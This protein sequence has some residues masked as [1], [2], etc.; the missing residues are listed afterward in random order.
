MRYLL[1]SFFFLLTITTVF[2]QEV[3]NDPN[4][5][6]QQ[7]GGNNSD[8]RI[9]AVTVAGKVTLE[10]LPPSQSKPA[11]YIIVYHNSRFNQ[12]QQVSNSGSY[13]LNNVPRFN[14]ILAIEIEKN[15][16]IQYSIVPSASS[17]IYQDFFVSWS[18]IQNSINSSNKPGVISAKDFYQR[19]DENQKLFDQALISVKEKKS[20]S[21]IKLFKQIIKN[22]A[23]DFIAWTQLGNIYFINEKL[24]EAEESYAQALEQKPDYMLAL[25]NLG[26]VQ[27]AKNAN[28]KAIA[29]LTKLVEI[30]PKSADAQHYLGEAYLQSKKGSKAVIYLNE[31]IRLA[32]I[33]KAEVHLRLATLYHGAGL[34]DRAALEYKQFLE[35]VS[36]YEEKDKLEKYVKENLPA[37]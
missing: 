12:R 2:S 23:K 24:D 4:H 15:E 6:P 9:D 7:V 5:L 16:I 37:Q 28:E 33:E 10:G 35:K 21:A 22:D 36:K 3:P 30:E 20:D 1:F 27:M 11:I 32:P 17:T 31:A 13:V 8:K 29:T 19:N 26:K 14:S 25:L 34:K 18:Q